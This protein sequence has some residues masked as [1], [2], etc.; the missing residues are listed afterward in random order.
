M[1]NKILILNNDIIYPIIS[2]KIDTYRNV[3]DKA[4][5]YYQH[6]LILELV[7]D[8]FS[9][10]FLFNLNRTNFV[11]TTLV[12]F[13]EENVECCVLSKTFL[14]EMTKLVLQFEV[15]HIDF[16]NVSQISK[17]KYIERDLNIKNILNSM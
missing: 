16:I 12:L 10:G 8:K 7:P 2:Y 6:S 15:V 17:L 5:L 4:M 3:N 11:E 14:K 9:I 1:F 13:S